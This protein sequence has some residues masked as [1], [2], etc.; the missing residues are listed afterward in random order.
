ML[1]VLMGL[2][3]VVVGVLVYFVLLCSGLFGSYGLFF[4]LGVMIIV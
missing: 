4:L 1:N 3:L 2:F